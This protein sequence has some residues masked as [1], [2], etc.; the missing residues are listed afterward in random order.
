MRFLCVGACEAEDG[1][2]LQKDVE[3]E[4]CE[5]HGCCITLEM[6]ALQ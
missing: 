1:T 5:F 3:E 6:L 4:M 2:T